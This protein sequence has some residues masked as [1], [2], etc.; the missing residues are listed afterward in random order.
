MAD[1]T[2]LNSGSGG[3]TVRDVFKTV[4]QVKTQVVMLDV[5]GGTISDPESIVKNY[6]PVQ[7][8]GGTPVT[9]AL[10]PSGG[11]GLTGWLS[12]IWKALGSLAL[13]ASTNIVGYMGSLNFGPLIQTAIMTVGT[14]TTGMCIGSST[15][16]AGQSAVF[17]LPVFRNTV[18]PSATLAQFMVGLLTGESAQL[19]CYLFSK[20]PTVSTSLLDNAV[21]SFAAADLKYLVCPPFPLTPAVTTGSTEAIGSVALSLPA[22]NND[23]PTTQNLYLVLVYASTASLTIASGKQNDLW[24]SLSGVKD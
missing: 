4:T 24:F 11:V 17:T 6:V 8:Q 3:D 12:A 9:G 1:N 18:Q 14:Y 20:N 19:V 13:A 7:E 22:Q 21:P 2:Q 15:G 16:V 5:G 23:T 10:I